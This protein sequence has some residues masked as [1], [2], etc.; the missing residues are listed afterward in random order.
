MKRWV[1][2][3]VICMLLVSCTGKALDPKIRGALEIAVQDR[4]KLLDFQPKST[5]ID[6]V[7]GALEDIETSMQELVETMR[8]QGNTTK[9]TQEYI[10]ATY[11]DI[12]ILLFIQNRNPDHFGIVV[13]KDGQYYA[14]K[15]GQAQAKKVY[16]RKQFNRFTPGTNQEKM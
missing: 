10:E 15:A 6:W 4:G 13:L 11:R 8:I 7:P 14:F 3:G 12:S 5:R 2:L 16:E 9:P 1:A